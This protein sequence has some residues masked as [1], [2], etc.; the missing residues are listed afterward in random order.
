MSVKLKMIFCVDQIW[1][2]NTRFRQKKGAFPLFSFFRSPTRNACLYL[3][4][5]ELWGSSFWILEDYCIFFYSA[6]CAFL[7]WHLRLVTQSASSFSK[8]RCNCSWDSWFKWYH[9]VEKAMARIVQLASLSIQW[10]TSVSFAL[11]LFPFRL[12]FPAILPLILCGQLPHWQR[13]GAEGT[14]S[15]KSKAFSNDHPILDPWTINE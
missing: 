5:P 15:S 8:T 4:N 12:H 10:A 13:V 11:L 1:W 2:K 9:T 6:F 3:K 7:S 14:S